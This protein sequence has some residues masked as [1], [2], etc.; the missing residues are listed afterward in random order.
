MKVHLWKYGESTY[1]SDPIYDDV[2]QDYM[3]SIVRWDSRLNSTS[4][5]VD[6]EILHDDSLTDSGLDTDGHAAAFNS[7]IGVGTNY[8]Q[9]FSNGALRNYIFRP[10]A[11]KSRNLT[12]INSE[13]YNGS[14]YNGTISVPSQMDENGPFG[15][16][17]GEKGVIERSVLIEFPVANI[18]KVKITVYGFEE[19]NMEPIRINGFKVY[20]PLVDSN[21]V[22]VWPSASTSWNIVLRANS[23]T[24]L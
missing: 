1:D 6:V 22:A 11:R 24:S 23:T 16:D 13:T 5:K 14:P 2:I 7:V 18:R 15:S 3:Y 21:G 10:N 20:S 4:D 8:S 12:I 9:H 19:N 17:Q